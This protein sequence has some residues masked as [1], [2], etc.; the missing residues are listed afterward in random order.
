MKRNLLYFLILLILLSVTYYSEEIYKPKGELDRKQAT[1]LFSNPETIAKISLGKTEIVKDMLSWTVR[2]IFLERDED[3]L[4][5]FL[6]I[7]E[8]ISVVSSFEKKDISAYH[9]RM[10]LKFTVKEDNIDRT[11]FLG[12]I[13]E[14][15]GAFYISETINNKK[16]V[17][18]C[19]DESLMQ[20]IHKNQLDLDFKKYVRLQEFIELKN[21]KLQNK[22]LSQFFNLD[23]IGTIHI[24]N[25][26]NKNFTLNLTGNVTTPL[27]PKGIM[28]YELSSAFLT[29]LENV[30]ITEVYPSG[31]YLLDNPT[32]EI[33]FK[34]KGNQVT[35]KLYA[36]LNG[37]FG[38]YLKFSNKDFIL[39]VNLKSPNVFFSNMQDY[40]DKRH[41]ISKEKVKS[42]QRLKFS[43]SRN[44]KR[45]EFYVDDFDK[46][47]VEFDKTKVLGVSQTHF[48]MLFNLLFNLV[49]YKSAKYIVP[50]QKESLEGIMI[51][52]L[53]ESYQVHFDQGLLRVFERSSQVAYYYDYNTQLIDDG[54]FSNIFTVK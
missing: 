32:A 16:I 36:S 45:Y 4:K 19:Y 8:H 29:Y 21:L 37:E 34:V 28:P 41:L 2:P 11:F 6:N 31:Q 5:D 51:E 12:D 54:F 35:L 26:R 47:I 50:A 1:R 9:R 42:D 38:R 43:L 30:S 40:W 44:S 18:I 13:S 23:D 25:K 24:D 10:N 27:P 33:N 46:F 48:N 39:K 52:L 22:S 15:T 3:E 49:D 20:D 7:I 17:H 53:G 14:S